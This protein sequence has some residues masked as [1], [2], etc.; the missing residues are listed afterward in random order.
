MAGELLATNRNSHRAKFDRFDCPQRE[1][2]IRLLAWIRFHPEG[3]EVPALFDALMHEQSEAHWGTTQGDA[4]ALLALTEYARR[5]EGVPSPPPG[6]CAGAAKPFPSSWTRSGPS[7]RK[8]S[9]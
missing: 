5:V 3:R 4:W 2:A 8:H 7:L 6:S 9:S 1:L